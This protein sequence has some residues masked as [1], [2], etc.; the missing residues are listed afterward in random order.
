[1]SDVWK[2]VSRSPQTIM[3]Y[4]ES[5]TDDDTI[6]SIIESLALCVHRETG[7]DVSSALET[8]A[9][10]RTEAESSSSE[11]AIMSRT[12]LEAGNIVEDLKQDDTMIVIKQHDDM[13]ASEKFLD[14]GESVADVNPEYDSDAPVVDVKY[15]ENGRDYAFPR[16]RLR[17]VADSEHNE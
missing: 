10:L 13:S 9:Q 3:S 2:H 6:A 14:T 1:M 12:P 17:K 5:N 7:D 15:H 11:S 16:D 4:T 8:A